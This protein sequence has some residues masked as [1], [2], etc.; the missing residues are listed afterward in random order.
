MRSRRFIVFLLCLLC[1]AGAWFLW[2]HGGHSPAQK[3]N[4]APT[5]VSTRS[6]S[7]APKVPSQGAVKTNATQ[8]S[9]ADWNTNKFA[10][11]LNNTTRT[12]G[13]LVNDSHAILLENA[14]IDTRTPLNLVFPKNLQSQGD[15]GAYIVQARGPTDNAFRA[16][17]AQAGATIVAYIPNDAYL[18]RASANVAGMLGANPQTQSVIPYEPYYKIQSS[19]LHGA[20]GQMQLPDGAILNLGLFAD[21]A[22]ATIQ[23]IQKLGGQVVGR[24]QS[25]FGPIVRVIPPKNWTTLAVLSGVQIVE[26]Y[27]ARAPANDLSRATVGV[28]ANSLTTTNYLGLTGKN[29]I[30]EVNDTGIDANHPDLTPARVFGDA[31]QSLVDTSGHGTHVA[32]IIAGDG[33][34]SK[35]V[36]NAPGSIIATLPGPTATNFQFRGM[37]P[38][39]TLFSV[40]ALDNNGGKVVSDQLL[41]EIPALTNALI[42]NNSWTYG[43][44][45]YDLA[46]ASYDAAT[47]DALP[48]VIGSQPV[49]FVFAAGNAGNGNDGSDPGGGVADSIESPATAKNVITVGAI[50][51]DRNI[52]NVVTTV[53][54]AN[55]TNSGEPWQA[56]TST[57]SRV[58]GFSSR[59]NVGIGTEGTFG[60]YKP[61]VVAPGTFI[62]STRSEQWDIGTYFFQNPT[63]YQV[64]SFS[65]IVVKPG[66]LFTRV[67]PSVSSNAV[68][69]TINVYPN[70][71]S[72]VPFPDLAIYAGLF[73]TVGYDFSIINDDV[74][75]PGS[76]GV[77]GGYLQ[78][79]IST[80]GLN[81]F[82][83]AFNYAVSNNTANPI[84]FNLQTAILTTNGTGNYFLVL[85]NLDESL[86]TSPHYY[87]YET[88]TSMSAA[89]VSGVLALM[90]E[91]YTNAYHV[92][93]SPALL[94]A[95]LVSG[96]QVT[97]TSYNYQAQNPVNYEGWGLLNLPDSLPTGITNQLGLPCTSYIQEQSPTNALAT[98]DSQTFH[99]TTTSAQPLRVTL[100][101]TDPPGDPAAAIK[102]VN[103]LV[104]VVTNLSDSANPVVYF[105]ND[106]TPSSTFSFPRNTN[107]PPNFDSINNVQN[108]NLQRS[109][110]TNFYVTVLG[111][112]VNVN[113]VTAHTNNVVQDYALVISCSSGQVTNVMTVT[114]VP[115][116]FVSNPTSDQQITF[117]TGNNQVLLNQFA[118]RF[119]DELAGDRRH[120]QSVA[121]LRGDQHGRRHQFHLCQRGVCYV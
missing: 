19:L 59:G 110:G 45:T 63:N 53:N 104:L 86:C 66:S 97:G 64:K 114:A 106:F 90:Q 48:T 56:E 30:V 33:T 20:V 23:Q 88:G 15:P 43:N 41:Q 62:I 6:L 74:L 26:P 75:I 115:P 102:L 65:G 31:P 87:R 11:R 47:R 83:G 95:M 117:V 5:A 76:P 40:T 100:V 84:S 39:A 103:N 24:D 51:E 96:A 13:Q 54:S 25:P 71:Q 111:Y 73:S 44:S 3:K 37:A 121:F 79:I 109:T 77:P 85:S 21:N 78:S 68:Q 22:P 14:L 7:T 101:W 34:E 49:L 27:H 10:G 46:A 60:R 92:L 36:T 91:F 8:I 105:G 52:T 108:V 81:P 35:T 119:W 58:A 12:I 99:V 1:G 28:A 29:V 80:E 4:I 116:P 93:P 70:A 16:I 57:S 98:G 50:Q 94:K 42:S 9:M 2:H 69:L 38:E 67:F 55:V 17:L 118:G 18:V 107:T 120:D 32:G 61:D 89:D 82:A 113:A 112:R 72:P